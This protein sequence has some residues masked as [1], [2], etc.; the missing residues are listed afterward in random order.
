MGQASGCIFPSSHS[1]EGFLCPWSSVVSCAMIVTIPRTECQ[2]HDRLSL[3]IEYE[4][5]V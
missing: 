1:S 2:K 4:H 5:K 3:P